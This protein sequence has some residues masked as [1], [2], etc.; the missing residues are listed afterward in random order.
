MKK[1]HKKKYCLSCVHSYALRNNAEYENPQAK[2]ASLDSAIKRHRQSLRLEASDCDT[3]MPKP[4]CIDFSSLRRKSHARAWP[5]GRMLTVEAE[6]I[7]PT[8]MPDEHSV[9][10]RL[11]HYGVKF[12]RDPSVQVRNNGNKYRAGAFQECVIS[13][14]DD[15]Y[16][17]LVK[18]LD[19]MRNCGFTVNKTCGLHVH[20]DAR[21]LC[22]SWVGEKWLRMCDMEHQ[23]AWFIPNWTRNGRDWVA[24][25]SC[26]QLGDYDDVAY[27]D[28]DLCDL[29]RYFGINLAAFSTHKTLEVRMMSGTLRSEIVVGWVRLLS[30]IFRD[31]GIRNLRD[32]TD[33]SIISWM[34]VRSSQVGTR[35]K[36]NRHLSE[37]G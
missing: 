26:H 22:Q 28:I 11:S 2:K 24:M 29:E 16:A 1:H 6:F 17:R 9:Y 5:D 27:E 10:T 13:F 3:V 35:D 4:D 18:V 36:L 32:I 8:D 15:N 7:T 30:A 34:K 19:C 23:L 37:A 33:P 21:H 31:D 14:R 20:L 12:K 25:P